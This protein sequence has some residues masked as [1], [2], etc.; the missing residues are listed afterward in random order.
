MIMSIPVI[1]IVAL[2]VWIAWRYMGLRVWQALVAVIL[3]FLLAATPAAPA[4]HQILSA[5][6]LWLQHL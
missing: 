5:V 6:V 2:V 3:G 1:A 4:M